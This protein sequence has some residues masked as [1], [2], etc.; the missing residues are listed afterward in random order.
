MVFKGWP[1]VTRLKNTRKGSGY[2]IKG[3][4][5]TPTR[6]K[7]SDAIWTVGMLITAWDLIFLMAENK[8][9]SNGVLFLAVLFALFAWGTFYGFRWFAS[10]L[11]FVEIWPDVIRVGK[12]F[13]FDE[14][15]R[16]LQHQ[17]DLE[18]HEKAL[19]ENMEVQQNSKKWRYF[20]DCAW[21]VLRHP[22]GSLRIAP[23]Y[24]KKKA[25]RL[26]ER[27]QAV[28]MAGQ[29]EPH[30]TEER[31]GGAPHTGRRPDPA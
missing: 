30:Q 25:E 29:Y 20:M 4:Y 2:R 23:I 16:T 18:E 28:E 11:A 17:F 14:Y 21:V 5:L 12:Q 19:D 13:R 22:S 9:K 24:P 27:L 3:W 8:V 15:D 7:M 10:K 31:G 26:L 1:R 6:A